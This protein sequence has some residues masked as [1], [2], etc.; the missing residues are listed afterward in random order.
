MPSAQEESARDSSLW[1]R[2]FLSLSDRRLPL[3][4]CRPCARVIRACAVGIAG[5]GARI[6]RLGAPC[7]AAGHWCSL[8][9]GC[10]CRRAPQFRAIESA[11]PSAAQPCVSKR[12]GPP[13]VREPRRM[14]TRRDISWTR[15]GRASGPGRLEGVNFPVAWAAQAGATPNRGRWAGPDLYDGKAR[16]AHALVAQ[17]R[18]PGSGARRTWPG[19][20]SPRTVKRSATCKVHIEGRSQN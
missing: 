2:A 19:A 10:R 7:K 12:D 13:A 11:V 9:H 15:M 4:A 5:R 20:P 8:P 17:V 3:V 1:Q 14:Q 6:G 18:G 16:Q